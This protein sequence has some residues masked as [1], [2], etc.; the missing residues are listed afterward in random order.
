[1]LKFIKIDEENYEVRVTN[2]N[3]HD[4]ELAGK[5]IKDEN[6]MWC[7][8]YRDSIA[9]GYSLKEAETDL[10]EEFEDSKT[11]HMSYYFGNYKQ[12]K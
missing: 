9:Y 5:L 8:E 12:N 10:E 2:G 6:D 1:M 7:F 11:D 3:N 4:W